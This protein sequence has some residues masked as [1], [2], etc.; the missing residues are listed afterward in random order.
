MGIGERLKLLRKAEKLTQEEAA[1][2][3][4]TKRSNYANWEVERNEP[5]SEDLKKIAKRFGV[6]VDYLLTGNPA[7]SSNGAE[8]DL[9]KFLEQTEIFFDGAPIT[10][11]ERAK[12]RHALEIVFWDSKE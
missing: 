12:I 8:K 1:T 5:G 6:S 10:K 11:A 9:S 3:L 7:V 2:S 4:G